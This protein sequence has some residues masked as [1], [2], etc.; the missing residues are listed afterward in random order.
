MLGIYELS[1]DELKICLADPGADRPKEFASAKGSKA[2]YMV[3]K[4]TGK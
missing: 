4:R 2:T 3:L 1:G